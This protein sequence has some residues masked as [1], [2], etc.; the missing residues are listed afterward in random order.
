[1]NHDALSDSARRVLR[2]RE[3]ETTRL[4]P[5]H[6]LPREDSGTNRPGRFDLRP[7]IAPGRFS[8]SNSRRALEGW[9]KVFAAFLR[10][11]GVILLALLV[12][13]LCLAITLLSLAILGTAAL[14]RRVSPYLR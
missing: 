4:S 10:L 8:G 13:G 5:L 7:R 14:V 9:T 3:R 6:P 2:N 1:M 12:R 11:V